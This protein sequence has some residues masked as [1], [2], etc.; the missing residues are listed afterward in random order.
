MRALII[1]TGQAADAGTL[2][3]RYPVPMLPLADRPFVRH[4]VEHLVRQGVRR[5]DWV[6]SHLPEQIEGFLGDGRRWGAEFRFHLVPDPA[7][8]YEGLRALT[9]PGAGGEPVL[10]GHADRLPAFRLADGPAPARGALL[11]GWGEGGPGPDGLH[12]SGWAVLSAEAWLDLPRDP[13]DEGALCRA[14]ARPAASRW[15]EVPRPLSVRG[16]AALRAANEAVLRGEVPGLL[17]GGKAAEEGV[18]LAPGARVHPSAELVAPVYLGEGCEVA[19]GA[20]VGPNAVVA[21]VALWTAAP[22]S[23][24]RWSWRAPTSARA[25]SC[26]APWRTATASPG[27][28][29]AAPSASRRTARSPAWPTA[30]C[31]AWPGGCCRWPRGRRCCCWRRRCCCWWRWP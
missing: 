13:A 10:L 3:D 26:A 5:F 29:R 15:Q 22:S 24:A 6:L 4:V 21:R 30:A 7:R 1:A 23:P 16:L 11:Y 31:R 2:D 18:W 28:R 8:P 17:P 14:L 25:W 19:A 20:R 9:P 12:W 27:P